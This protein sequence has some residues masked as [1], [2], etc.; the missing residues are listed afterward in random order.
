[1]EERIL[2]FLSQLNTENEP[3][4]IEAHTDLFET[5]ILDSF[6]FVELVGFLEKETGHSVTEEDMEDPR[7]TTVSGIVQVLAE[8]AIRAPQVAAGGSR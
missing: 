3:S 8:K 5:G 1:M 4:V 2:S 7:F 6:G